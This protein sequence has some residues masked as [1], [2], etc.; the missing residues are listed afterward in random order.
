MWTSLIHVNV[1]DLAMNRSII[2]NGTQLRRRAAKFER[3]GSRG[4]ALIEALVSML[5]FAFGVLGLVGL[6]ASMTK[7]QTGSK[8]RADASNL[9]SEL[10]GVMWSDKPGSL[11]SYASANCAA[12]A[13]CKDWNA[14]VAKQLPGA[15]TV[16]VVN[17]AT[18]EVDVTITWT[19]AGEGQHQYQT[20][21]MVQL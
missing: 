17:A 5:I 14:K 7:A 2:R 15:A 1:E 21:A 13:R 18:G 16:V 8:F 11:G 12:Y 6:Q 20:S 3:G 9:S 10:L 4:F 19:Q